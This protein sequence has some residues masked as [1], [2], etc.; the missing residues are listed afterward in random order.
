M[1]KANF[2]PDSLSIRWKWCCIYNPHPFSSPRPEN[3][4]SCT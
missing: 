4:W 1:T 2:S 3:Y